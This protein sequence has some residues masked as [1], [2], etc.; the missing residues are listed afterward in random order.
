MSGSDKYYSS[1]KMQM[2]IKENEK[3]RN[4]LQ[5]QLLD[6]RKLV[7]AKQAPEEWFMPA[8]PKAKDIE[9]IKENEAPF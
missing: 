7:S 6:G 8:M 2:L 4:L 9:E 5:K 3:K 1:Y